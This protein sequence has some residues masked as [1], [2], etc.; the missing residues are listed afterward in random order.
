[1]NKGGGLLLGGTGN[2]VEEEVSG[3]R[4]KALAQLADLGRFPGWQ[5]SWIRKT[6][7]KQ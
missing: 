1:M 5:E 6:S 7:W 4:A 2:T 3:P